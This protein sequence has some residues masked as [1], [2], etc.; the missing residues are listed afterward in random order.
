[1]DSYTLVAPTHVKPHS[2]QMIVSLLG[3]CRYSRYYFINFSIL[4][5]KKTSSIN[6]FSAFGIL[7]N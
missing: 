5:R 4:F 3:P 6:Y 1:M 7:S 2:S